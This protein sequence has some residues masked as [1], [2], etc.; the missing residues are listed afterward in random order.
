VTYRGLAVH[1]LAAATVDLD[2]SSR[3]PSK[4]RCTV[5][6]LVVQDYLGGELDGC[7]YPDSRR[8]SPT[9]VNQPAEP[10]D[11]M[12]DALARGLGWGVAQMS[13]WGATSCSDKNGN[14]CGECQGEELDVLG[15]SAV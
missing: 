12:H 15:T 5:T 2:W 4:G 11:A 1:L 14:V 7:N 6:A 10:V 8:I 9:L 13:R 3:R